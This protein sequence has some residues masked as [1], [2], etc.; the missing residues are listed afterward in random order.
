MTFSKIPI[1]EEWVHRP[2]RRSKFHFQPET[3]LF[4]E[5]LNGFFGHHSIRFYSTVFDFI[6]IKAIFTA[7]IA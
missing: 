3:K 4:N 5:V 2:E 6:T 1:P 7:H